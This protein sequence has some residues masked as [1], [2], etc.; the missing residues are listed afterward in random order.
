MNIGAK[1]SGKRRGRS[2][3][4]AP[5]GDASWEFPRG[6]FV[7]GRQSLVT[8]LRGDDHAR[9]LHVVRGLTYD[10]CC[11][12]V[13]YFVR[14]ITPA[15]L[16]IRYNVNDKKTI[17][18]MVDRIRDYFLFHRLPD[19]KSVREHRIRSDGP[20]VVVSKKTPEQIQTQLRRAQ[21]RF[22]E[23]SRHN[24]MYFPPP[25]AMYASAR[26]R[27]GWVITEIWTAWRSTDNAK[28][29]IHRC[30]LQHL[31]DPPPRPRYVVP[32]DPYAGLTKRE[33]RREEHRDAREYERMRIEQQN[34][35]KQEWE[36]R[37]SRA[38]LRERVIHFG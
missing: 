3:P 17:R 10:Q 20:E 23:E 16:A 12:F 7:F 5:P 6:R 25:G 9:V 34:R 14:G 15:D 37:K 30:K 21:E 29:T 32:P 24:A 4:G 33:R 31:V 26:D 22:E 11:V 36:E 8:M 18:K 28:R 13:D 35:R 2:H 38:P 1:W 19:P 27:N